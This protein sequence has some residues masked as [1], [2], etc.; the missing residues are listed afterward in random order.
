MTTDLKHRQEMLTEHAAAEDIQKDYLTTMLSNARDVL[1]FGNFYK[2]MS[3]VGGDY[4][5]FMNS[6]EDRIA[7][8]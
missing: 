2:S 7:F 1:E 5:D 4:F 8:V 3:G 6:G